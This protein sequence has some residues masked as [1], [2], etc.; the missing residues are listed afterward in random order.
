MLG[1]RK[2]NACRRISNYSIQAFAAVTSRE[3]N[4]RGYRPFTMRQL[5]PNTMSRYLHTDTSLGTSPSPKTDWKSIQFSKGFRLAFWT[6]V[7]LFVI[8]LV[9]AVMLVV[10]MS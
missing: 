6:I 5:E 4:I 2:R 3:R 10:A 8:L 7:T 1:L 9:G